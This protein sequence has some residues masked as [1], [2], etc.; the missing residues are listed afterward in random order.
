MLFVDIETAPIIMASWSMRPPYAGAVYVLRDT[1]ILMFSYKW[2]HEKTVK[3]VSL[4]DFPR[5]KRSKHDDKDLC[6]RIHSLM[7]EADIICAHNGDSFDI[8]KINSRL[9]V[10]DF[11]PPSPFK[12]ID[13]LK[14]AR[15]VFKFDS[16][17]LDN[18][19]RYL[20]EGRK[21]PNAGAALW[22]GTVDGD[23]KSIKTM[24]AYCKHDTQL[25]FNVYTRM[26]PWIKN[27]PNMTLYGDSMGCPAC[28]STNVQKRGVMVKLSS[29]RH[30]FHCQDCGSW[31]AGKAI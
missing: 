28:E 19:G 4:S 13:T 30:R 16:N 18:I 14:S 22:Q 11:G 26:K 20:K 31:F 29:R 5:Y 21:I 8:K 24:R 15:N 1:Y 10:N 12:T 6:G 27:H 9:I 3:T 17:K 25:L 7:D 23:P 2:A